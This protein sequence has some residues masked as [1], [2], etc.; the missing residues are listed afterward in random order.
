MTDGLEAV[1]T[2]VLG[3]ALDA[4]ALRQQAIA[5]NIANAN[6]IDY[7]PLEVSFEAQ[8]D[9]ARRALDAGGRL[10]LGSLAGVE[11]VL[12]PAYDAATGLPAQ[13]MV[14]A[15]V[16]EMARNAV[17]YQAL[18]KGLSRHYGILGTAIADGK[19]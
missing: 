15:E 5:S 8:L 2:A 17:H 12:Q 11:P 9:D 3:M 18:L 14:D 16:A 10:D 7:V 19:K 13:V 1:T 6:T 4:A